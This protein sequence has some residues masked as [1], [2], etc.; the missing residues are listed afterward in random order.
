MG[1]ASFLTLL[2]QIDFLVAI[3]G[4]LLSPTLIEEGPLVSE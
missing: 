4:D 1:G 2:G 3:S